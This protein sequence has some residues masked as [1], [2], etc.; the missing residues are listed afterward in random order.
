MREWD[1]FSD[2]DYEAIYDSMVKPAFVFDGR[3]LLDLEALQE[4]GFQAFGMGKG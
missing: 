1:I 4:I 3:N 2:L